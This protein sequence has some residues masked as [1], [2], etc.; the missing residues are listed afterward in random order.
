MCKGRLPK[1]IIQDIE[2]FCNSTLIPR[3]NYAAKDRATS[4]L[5][6]SY[7]VRV[8]KGDIVFNSMP[9]APPSGFMAHNYSK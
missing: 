7:S 4:A 5:S 1:P 3:M 6:G 2:G 8:Q 9:M